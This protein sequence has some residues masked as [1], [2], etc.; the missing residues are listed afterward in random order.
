VGV[1]AVLLQELPEGRFPIAYASKKLLP[2]ERNYAT[3]EKE[4]LAIVYAVKKF[5]KYLY[6]KKFILH[7]DHKPL[8]YIQTNRSESGRLMRW[9]LFL[10][11]YKFKIEAIKGSENIGA[12]YLSRQ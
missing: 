9:A 3:I 7:T 5:Q 1:G 11:C 6:G 12:D 10:Q 2:R 4:C 8:S